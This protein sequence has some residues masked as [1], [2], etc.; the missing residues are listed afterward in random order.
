MTPWVGGGGKFRHVALLDGFAE[1]LFERFLFAVNE[2]QTASIEELTGEATADADGEI[3]AVSALLPRP[4]LEQ[5][6]NPLR[7]T[8][9]DVRHREVRHAGHAGA[10]EDL[11]F[12][13]DGVAVLPVEIAR[14]EQR[15]GLPVN[16]V[17]CSQPRWFAAADPLIQQIR[18]APLVWIVGEEPQEGAG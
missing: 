3:G 9:G 10:L 15:L 8:L 5:R 12:R 17:L 6:R 16:P 14:A 1:A 2:I 7:L 4:E 18:A 11:P 13:V